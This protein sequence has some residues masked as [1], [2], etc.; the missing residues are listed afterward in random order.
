M[1]QGFSY[2]TT[3]TVTPRNGFSGTVNLALV[4]GRGKPVEGVS[5]SPTSMTVNSGPVKKSPYPD[6]ALQR[7]HRNLCPAGQGYLG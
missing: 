3:L 6:G 4:D 7:G 5:L 1:A 2:T